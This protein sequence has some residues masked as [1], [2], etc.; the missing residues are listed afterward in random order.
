[1]PLSPDEVRCLTF[2]QGYAELGMYADA[3]DELQALDLAVWETPEVM[4][5]RV[6]VYEGLK[7]W[8]LLQDVAR[9]M[10]ELKPDEP[11]WT[12]SFAFATRYVNSVEAARDILLNAAERLPEVSIFHYN[13]A[14]YECLLGNTEAVWKRL[15]LAFAI[16]ASWRQVALGD[17]DLRPVWA[18][19][20]A[21][22]I[23]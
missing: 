9:K 1:M 7:K 11:Q 17:A 19:I 14:C 4:I 10:A 3:N 12:I 22:R 13:L 5:V 23:S 2:A 8:D 16:D 6:A 18:E 20:S 15:H 21:N